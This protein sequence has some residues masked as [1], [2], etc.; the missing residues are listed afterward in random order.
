MIKESC[1]GSARL[2]A[3]QGEGVMSCF[4]SS[5]TG[6]EPGTHGCQDVLISMSPARFLLHLGHTSCSSLVF[7]L[8]LAPSG[9]VKVA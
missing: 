7:L 4:S 2:T 5:A 3:P 8:C 9:K 1:D 6:R